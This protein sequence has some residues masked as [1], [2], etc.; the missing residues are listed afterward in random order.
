MRIGEAA[1]R[2]GVSARA[3][4]YYEEEGLIEPARS[5]GGHRTYSEAVVEQVLFIRCL[6]AAGLPGRTIL[7]LLPSVDTGFT[8]PDMVHRLRTER[9]RMS[10]QIVSMVEA[11][12]RLDEL[13]ADAV[14]CT[15]T[16]HPRPVT[17][18][19]GSR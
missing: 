5:S 16:D 8:T 7:T 13:I 3:L 12:E 18:R 19:P 10:A 2:A 15:V 4:R 17:G 6:Q 14:R 11:R 1:K 9:D